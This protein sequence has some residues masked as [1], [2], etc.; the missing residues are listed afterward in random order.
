MTRIISGRA[1]GRRLETPPGSG[2]RP[3]TDRVREALFS[4][5]E[6]GFGPLT[7]CRVLDL[8]A[9]SG[10]IG[11]EA[12][13]RGAAH[14]TLV[15]ADR[16]AAATI[17]RNVTTLGL[18]EAQVERRSVESY[19]RAEP[20]MPFDLMVLDPPYAA[21][22]A[23]LLALLERITTAP[24]WAADG[25]VVVERSTR[26]QSFTWPTAVHHHRHK[27]YGETALW[28]GRRHA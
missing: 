19:T 27:A 28:Y 17:A 21:E 20:P 13:S 3:T 22:A 23:G 4:A 24:W 11:L 8:F 16:R 26:D 2:T 7:G 12:L 9:G 10:A 15:E 5:V 1:G 6:S 18:Q 14:A 25:W